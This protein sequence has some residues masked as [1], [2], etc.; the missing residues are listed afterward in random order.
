MLIHHPSKIHGRI[1]NRTVLFALLLLLEGWSR[2]CFGSPGAWLNVCQILYIA[3]Q[4]WLFYFLFPTSYFHFLTWTS[5]SLVFNFLLLLLSYPGTTVS[6][7]Q[8]WIGFLILYLILYSIFPTTGFQFW[9][10][11]L[12]LFPLSRVHTMFYI[13]SY[14]TT[15]LFIYLD[16]LNPGPCTELYPPHTP[17]LPFY[18]NRI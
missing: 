13:L 16:V 3:K 15:Y 11:L 1:L 7:C 12:A 9:I 17:H 5:I 18:W 8:C 6:D 10:L 2:V 14:C 4:I